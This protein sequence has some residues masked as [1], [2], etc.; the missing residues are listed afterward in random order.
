VKESAGRLILSDI[1][2]SCSKQNWDSNT[3]KLYITANCISRQYHGS[4]S[5]N[6]RF[7]LR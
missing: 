1:F 3:P 2:N 4:Q 7:K 5:S 6:I